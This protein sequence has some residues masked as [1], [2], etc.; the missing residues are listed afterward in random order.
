MRADGARESLKQAV[1]HH[2]VRWVAFFSVFGLFVAGWSRVG[3]TYADAYRASAKWLLDQ[4][5]GA[6]LVRLDPLEHPDAGFLDT[7]VIVA[8]RGHL[9]RPRVAAADFAISTR[10]TG[11]FELTF[12]LA[13]MI[14]TPMGWRRRAW[15]VPVGL[16]LSHGASMARLWVSV[17]YQGE[18]H[19]PLD[20]D[21]PDGFEMVL[22]IAQESFVADN[23]E[24][25]LLSSLVIWGLVVLPPEA[26]QA[27]FHFDDDE[28]DG[29]SLAP[30]DKKGTANTST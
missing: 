7:K 12:L 29:P 13:L 20:L 18:L 11:Y 10:Y 19:P 6:R 21:V 5:D 3:P 27:W 17:L 28:E 25:G 2:L 14:V 26:W 23:L 4:P 1:V 8:N 22:R 24:S 30:N 9:N 15:V 16:C